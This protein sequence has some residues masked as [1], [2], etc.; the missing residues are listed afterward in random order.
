MILEPSSF[1][2]RDPAQ[3]KGPVRRARRQQRKALK[4]LRKTSKSTNKQYRK[5]TRTERGLDF[6]SQNN[7]KF[8]DMIAGAVDKLGSAAAAWATGG[9]SVVGEAMAGPSESQNPPAWVGPAVLIGAVAALGY[10]LK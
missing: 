7:A 6:A 4:S 8:G 2:R 5:N 10:M 1:E 3:M 9:T